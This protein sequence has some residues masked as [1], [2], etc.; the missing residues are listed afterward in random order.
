MK[1]TKLELNKN[2]NKFKLYLDDEYYT[3]VFVDTVVKFGLKEGYEYEKNKI[4]EIIFD[5]E[6]SMAFDKAMRYLGISIKTKKQMK[7]YLLK[8][9][10][11]EKVADYVLNKLETYNYINDQKYVE[12][13]IASYKN[14]Y[15]RHKIKFSL[16]QKGISKNIVDNY[17]KNIEKNDEIVYN[18]AEKKLGNKEKTNEN[19]IKVF[20]FLNSRGFDIDEINSAINKLKRKE[21]D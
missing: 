5:S 7:D 17:L 19:L 1:I 18:L 10:F 16:I 14:K 6:K 4:D 3:D 8:K 11:N 15:G 21:V 12:S 9:G 20:R 2:K 13:Y